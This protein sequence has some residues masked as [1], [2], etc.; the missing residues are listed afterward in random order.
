MQLFFDFTGPF[1]IVKTIIKNEN[2]KFAS[3]ISSNTV[4]EI[5]KM[6]IQLTFY[7]KKFKHQ[8]NDKEKVLEVVFLIVFDQIIT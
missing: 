4:F 8:L 7:L 6:H 1:L 2:F 3:N 5:N